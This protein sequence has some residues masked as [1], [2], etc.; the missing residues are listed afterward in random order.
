MRGA[1]AGQ[2]QEF[3]VEIQIDLPAAMTDRQRSELQEREQ[4]AARELM[5][6]GRIQRIW[7]IPGRTAN[8][9]I[10]AAPDASSLHTSIASLPMFRWM[11]VTVHPL[12]VHPLE[13][14]A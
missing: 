12:A 14:E 7:R 10:W 9:G 11:T 6:A 2:Q 1:T 3:L 4:S 13:A 8:V 5:A